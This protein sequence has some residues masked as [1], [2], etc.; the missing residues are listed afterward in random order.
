MQVELAKVAYLLR[1]GTNE[2]LRAGT[3][4]SFD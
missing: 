4:T 2:G 3:Y 1:S